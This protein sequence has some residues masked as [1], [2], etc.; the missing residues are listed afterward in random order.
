MANPPTKFPPV[1]RLK[2]QLL[3]SGLQQQNT[4]LFQVINQLID[5]VR[6]ICQ[7]TQQEIDDIGGGG[8]GPPSII[9]TTTIL[10]TPYFD[11]GAEGDGE[12]GPPGPAGIDGIQ[13][14]QGSPGIGIPGLDGED[15]IDGETGPQG[16]PGLTGGQGPIGL[17]GM[18]GIDGIDGEQG[19]MG[20]PGPIGPTG[21]QGLIGIQ[22]PQGPPGIDAEEP[23]IPY[24]IPGPAGAGSGGGFTYTN[25]TKD[26]GASDRAGTFDI[27]GLAGLTIDKNVSVIQTMQP[28]ASKGDA[29][30]EFELSPIILTGYVFDA[31]TIRVLWNCDSVVVGDYAFAYAVSQ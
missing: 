30:D 16:P 10:G 25:F 2:A 19:E 22:G 17:P 12:S 11:S 14:P 1:D 4:P 21:I 18:A 29:R 20:I 8:S 31:A 23:E 6:Q 27:T 13:G 24:I 9:N 3:G 5:A 15:G 7:V 28:I 26:L